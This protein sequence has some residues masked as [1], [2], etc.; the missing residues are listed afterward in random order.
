M[1]VALIF[2]DRFYPKAQK[3][4]IALEVSGADYNMEEVS[5]YGA[6]GKPK[7]FLKLNPAGTVPV[8]VNKDDV[9]PDSELILDYIET[10]SLGIANNLKGDEVELSNAWRRTIKE[11]VA[12]IGKR[13]VLGGGRYELVELLKEID[14]DVKGPFLCG[15]TACVADCAAFPFIWRI[16]DEF[17][18]NECP[19]L[20]N[21]LEHCVSIPEFN[22]TIQRSWWWWW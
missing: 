21:W 3:A 15:E 12:P 2:T 10:R 1:N 13:A 20:Q 6:G 5:L 18:L 11:R 9:V 16:N 19:K 17:G 22:K 7:W 14:N 4:W 8:L